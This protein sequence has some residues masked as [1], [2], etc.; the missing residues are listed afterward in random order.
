MHENEV[1]RA[2]KTVNDSYIEPISFIV[3]RRAEVFQDDIYPPTTGISP[4]MS[5]SEWFAGKEALP[6]KIDMAKLYEGGVMKELP[7]DAVASTNQPEVKAPEPAKQAEPAP[8]PTPEPAPA[9][10]ATVI[11]PRAGMKEQ[12][13]SMAAAASKYMDNDEDEEEEAGGSSSF[14]AA[15]SQPQKVPSISVSPAQAEAS[16][17]SKE[18]PKVCNH[19]GGNLYAYIRTTANLLRSQNPLQNRQP[20]PLRLQLA[21]VPTLSLRSHR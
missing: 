21:R 9:P 13:A 5:S 4:A 6:P 14:D 1:V 2:Y 7:A 8:R 12:G 17:P 18:E 11:T 10:A 3:P 19:I 20:Q 16:Q 15:K